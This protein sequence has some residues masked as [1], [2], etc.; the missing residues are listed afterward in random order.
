MQ[1]IFPDEKIICPKMF[2]KCK[3]VGIQL[4][5]NDSDFFPLR[6]CE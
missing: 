4:I 5:S 1:K 3:G 6:D 2:H